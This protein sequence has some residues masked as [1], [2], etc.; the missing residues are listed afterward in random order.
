LALGALLLGVVFGLATDAR[1]QYFPWCA[2]S[3]GIPIFAL[4]MA[5]TVAAPTSAILGLI[6][7]RFFGRLPVH[8]WIWDRNRPV[9]SY[10]VTL[11]FGGGAAAVVVI[12]AIGLTSSDVAGPSMVLIAYLLASTRAALLAPPR[13]KKESEAEAGERASAG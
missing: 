2:D 1:R 10:L 3:I 4:A 7:A 11:I 12:W 6:I 5:L 8:L 9:R 13:H